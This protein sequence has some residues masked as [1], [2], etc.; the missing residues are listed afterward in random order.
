LNN[1]AAKRIKT[2]TFVSDATFYL[3]WK[4]NAKCRH[5]FTCAKINRKEEELSLLEIEKIFCSLKHP[6]SRLAY[7][8]GEPFLRSD[9]TQISRIIYKSKKVKKIWTGTN[10]I[11]SE[12]IYALSQ[13]IASSI[14]IP[15]V[16]TVSIE[17]MGA[18]HNQTVGVGGAFEKAINTVRLLKG[19]TRK[20]RNF[21]VR[22]LTTVSTKNLSEIEKLAKFIRF[23]L[24]V[25]PLF[26]FIWGSRS[27]CYSL[28]Q[29]LLADFNPPDSEFRLPS[30]NEMEEVNKKINDCIDKGLLSK[31]ESVRRRYVLEII[32][33]KKRLFLCQAS[34]CQN[35]IIYPAGDV[36]FCEFTRII[37]N[38]REVNYGLSR[39]FDSDLSR[40]INSRLK[41]CACNLP[42]ILTSSMLGNRRILKEIL[43]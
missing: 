11:E 18:L 20:Y 31:I 33:N 4:C 8:G 35:A 10:G 24:G 6:L 25:Y 3:T 21:Q 17:G 5:C 14:K 32:K 29:E 38:L 28:D 42:Y 41:N 9:I 30:L 27:S 23:D 7:A 22:T 37:G 43:I 36:S 39:L 26:N 40:A 16:V 2:K 19:L 13:E 1:L 34:N 12:R 15:F